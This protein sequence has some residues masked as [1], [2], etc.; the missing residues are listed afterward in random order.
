[1]KGKKKPH[2]IATGMKACIYAKQADVNDHLAKIPIEFAEDDHL[3]YLR[4][5]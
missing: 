2:D 5:L 4:T 1:M 3:Y